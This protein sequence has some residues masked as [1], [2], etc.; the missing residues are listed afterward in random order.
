MSSFKEYQPII[1]EYRKY[2]DYALNNGIENAPE[3]NI[4]EF[5]GYNFWYGVCLWYSMWRY[6]SLNNDDF[7]RR[8][9]FGYALKDL[10]ENGST[11]LILLLKDYT[12]LAVFSLVDNKP[13]LLDIFWNRHSCVIYDSGLLYTHSSGGANYWDYKIQR[14]SQDD[15]ELLFVEQYGDNGSYTGDGY[16]KM[17]NGEEYP[18]SESELEEALKRIRYILFEA[19]ADEIAEISGLEYI[20]LF[21]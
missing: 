19:T 2:I 13:N 18:I 6:S 3:S 11:E 10:N 14:I 15:S 21:D 17:V 1:E 16:Y 4:S 7:D 5:S 20:P 12:V 8:N 9:S